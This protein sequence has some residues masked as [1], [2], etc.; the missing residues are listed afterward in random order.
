M[1]AVQVV[2]LGTGMGLTQ[3]RATEAIMGAVPTRQ[4][5]IASAVN[6]CS[7]AVALVR[8]QR[9]GVGATAWEPS[10]LPVSGLQVC[11]AGP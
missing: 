3:A 10:S 1:I 4:A 11:C 6:G 2:V 7:A 8:E 5:G 9:P